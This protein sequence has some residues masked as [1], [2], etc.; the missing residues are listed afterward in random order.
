MKTPA[1]LQPLI[2]EGW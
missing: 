2:D 1:A